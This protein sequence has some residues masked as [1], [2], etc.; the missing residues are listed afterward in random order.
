MGASRDI[1][2]LSASM[3][4]NGAQQRD[5]EVVCAIRPPRVDPEAGT[6]CFELE[7]RAAKLRADLDPKRLALPEVQ[8]D[9]ETSDR[10]GLRPPRAE[11]DVHPLVLRIPLRAVHEPPL[12]EGRVELAIHRDECVAGERLGDAAP[13]V[14]RTLEASDVLDEVD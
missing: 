5:R 10:H 3:W 12:V 11:A 13:V 2:L 6:C 1:R 7:P 8:V 14:V 9:A 4:F